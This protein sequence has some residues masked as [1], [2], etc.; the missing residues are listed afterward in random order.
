MQN[1]KSHKIYQFLVKLA[2]TK[3]RNLF[4]FKYTAC[5]KVRHNEIT[6]QEI[7]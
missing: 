2:C 5:L 4:G 3:A 6:F 7:K 1:H